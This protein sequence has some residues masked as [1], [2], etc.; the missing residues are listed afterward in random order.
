MP[1]K[2][3][4][5]AFVPIAVLAGSL[6]LQAP[7]FAQDEADVTSRESLAREFSDPLTTLPLVGEVTRRSIMN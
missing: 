5:A 7:A 1:L 3:L 6:C 2:S 4:A